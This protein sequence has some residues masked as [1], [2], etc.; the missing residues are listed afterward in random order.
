MLPIFGPG[1]LYLTRT[2]IANA[3]PVNIGYA[4]SFSYSEQGDSKEL[5]GQNQ[6]PI[7]VARGTIK[8]TGKAKAATV[9]AIALNAAFHGDSFVTG[10]LLMAEKEAGS[11]PGSSTYT[12]TVANSAHFDTD[13]GVIYAATGLPLQKVASGPAAGQYSVS[14]GVYTFASG[15]ASANVLI[16]YAYTSSSGGQ[17]R[18][19]TNKALGTMPTFQ[20]D[21]SSKYNNKPYYAR[22]FSCVA[23]QLQHSH[24]L[25]D[26]T[27]PELDF[28]FYQNPAGNVYEA[29]F[30]EVS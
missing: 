30:P 19:V 1:S 5:F 24:A 17:T 14:A 21:Y 9:S 29:S 8:A 11:V 26:F 18:T 7:A 12:I 16:T 25:T 23:T 28:S 6:Y 4:Q 3:T 22:F 15:D 20:L 10:Q 2:D 27:M 13:L